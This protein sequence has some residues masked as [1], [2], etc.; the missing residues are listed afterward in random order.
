M[1]NSNGIPREVQEVLAE[2]HLKILAQLTLTGV[3]NKEASTKLGISEYAV[4]KIQETEEFKAEL[5]SLS[6]EMVRVASSTWKGAMGRLIPKALVALEKGLEA[7]K[8]D[9]VKVVMTS[10]GLDKV[11]NAP[12]SGTLQVIL[13]DYNKREKVIGPDGKEIK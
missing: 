6:D 12:Q 3:N 10:I 5:R 9:A 8:I 1:A 7:G 4:R 2:S 11:D 13:P